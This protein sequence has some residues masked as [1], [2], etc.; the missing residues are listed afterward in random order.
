[1][2]GVHRVA[3]LG[4]VEREPAGLSLAGCGDDLRW[5]AAGHAASQERLK[6][7]RLSSA[8]GK[9]A[10]RRG[11]SGFIITKASPPSRSCMRMNG[12]PA[13]IIFTGA[14]RGTV[15]PALPAA[16]VSSWRVRVSSC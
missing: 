8:C 13:I 3:G 15:V 16:A 11:Y 1:D 6:Y 4:T 5:R 7:L 12:W 14:L 9:E 2:A 10:G